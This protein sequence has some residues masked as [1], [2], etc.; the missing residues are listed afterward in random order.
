[1]Y[2]ISTRPATCYGFKSILMI[3]LLLRAHYQV[4][5]LHKTKSV[6]RCVQRIVKNVGEQFSVRI[7]LDVYSVCEQEKAFQSCLL[8][9]QFFSFSVCAKTLNLQNNCKSQY[10]KRRVPEA[11]MISLMIFVRRRNLCQV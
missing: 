5:K 3:S 2:T 4:A 7:F 9:L 1:M 8:S 11:G 6:R 10:L